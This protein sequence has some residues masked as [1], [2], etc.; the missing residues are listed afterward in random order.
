MGLKNF[1][2]SAF[3]MILPSLWAAA[4]LASD[5]NNHEKP[6]LE[7]ERLLSTMIGIQGIVYCRTGSKLTPLQGAVARVTCEGV[8]EY[9]YET[10]S[11]SVLSCAT[12][13]KG[14]FIATISPNEV[15]D[16]NRRLRNCKAF[17]EFS[18][19]E[20]CDVPTDVNKGVSGAPIGSFSR[21]HHKNI[22]LF[23]V[24]PFFLV[25]HQEAKSIPDG[26]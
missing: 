1:S 18:P 13:E 9:G 23:T 22:K 25:P 20:D 19:S 3:F 16:H 26:Y 24:G 14:Y 8:D 4:V 11:F 10:E 5:A 6:N 7:K 2:F 21:L 15:K 12:D 17:I